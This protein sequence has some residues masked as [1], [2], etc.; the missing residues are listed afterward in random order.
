MYTNSNLI[1]KTIL[2]PNNS[3]QRTGKIERLTVHCVVGQLTSEKVAS[4]FLKKSRKASS[5]YVI[6]KDGDVCLV[7]E[8]SNRSWCSSS[9]SND[10]K[11]ITIECASDT[12]DPYKF[13]Y[14]VYNKLIELTVDI[15]KRNNKNTLV[16]IN[17]KEKA[18]KYKVKENELLLTFH[19]WFAAKAC[20]GDWFISMCNN[21]DFITKVNKHFNNNI[22]I[23]EVKKDVIYIVKKGDTLSKIAKK[24]NTNYLKIARDN[25]IANPSLIRVGQKL[26]IKGV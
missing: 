4:M 24:Y 16:Y 14:I 3:G 8:E 23:E 18:L 5:N 13:N 1:N 19:R 15:M 6:G 10:Q 11:A 7:V 17:D 22:K 9:A 2:S 21:G 12:T 26:I 25:K 20:P